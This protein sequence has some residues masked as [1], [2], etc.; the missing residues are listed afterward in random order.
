V[1][2]ADTGIPLTVGEDVSIGHQAMLHGCTVGD[3]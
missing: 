3:G 2:H 1:L